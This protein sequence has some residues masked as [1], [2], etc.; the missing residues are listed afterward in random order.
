MLKIIL[1]IAKKEAEVGVEVVEFLAIHDWKK[2]R[3][4]INEFINTSRF[5][6]AAEEFMKN[7][8][9]ISNVQKTIQPSNSIV[10]LKTFTL[11]LQNLMPKISSPSR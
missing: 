1:Q 5:S 4:G 11:E 10:S 7:T 3:N 8:P 2:W 6:P 9:L